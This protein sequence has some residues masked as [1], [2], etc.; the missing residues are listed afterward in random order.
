MKNKISVCKTDLSQ[1]GKNVIF[2]LFH[3]GFSRRFSGSFRSNNRKKNGSQIGYGEFLETRSEN[4]FRKWRRFIWNRVRIWII[5]QHSP[6][7]TSKEYEVAKDKNNQSLQ[8]TKENLS[9]KNP[10]YFSFCV[11]S[12]TCLHPKPSTQHWNN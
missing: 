7:N 8:W 2:C 3:H 1:N 12:T 11:H 6:T 4:K 5:G 9:G 10:F